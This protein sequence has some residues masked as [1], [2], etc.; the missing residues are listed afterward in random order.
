MTA[1]CYLLKL[2]VWLF[3]FERLNGILESCHTNGH[4]IFSQADK[5][6]YGN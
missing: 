5:T 3:S 6:F 1:G 4:D 2:A